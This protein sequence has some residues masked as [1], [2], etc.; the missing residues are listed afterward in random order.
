METNEY[1]YNKKM[2]NSSLTAPTYI[3]FLQAR[4]YSRTV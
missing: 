3:L 1:H 2:Y 4:G